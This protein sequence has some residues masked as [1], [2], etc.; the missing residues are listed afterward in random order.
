M[1]LNLSRGFAQKSKNKSEG[2]SQ[3]P[4]APLP[5]SIIDL[6]DFLK[7]LVKIRKGTLLVQGHLAFERVI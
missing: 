1:W 2:L 3:Y 7:L 4:A 5:K 6:V